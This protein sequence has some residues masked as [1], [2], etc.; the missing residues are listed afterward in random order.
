V[1]IETSLFAIS[2]LVIPDAERSE[3]IRNPEQ[4]AGLDSGFA[5]G[6][7]RFARTRWTRP[8]MTA[9]AEC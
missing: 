2:H 8:G 1:G 3:A 5:P 9:R 7:P 4:R 6:G